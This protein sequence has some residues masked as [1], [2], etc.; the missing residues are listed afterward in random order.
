MHFVGA[1]D[2]LALC[3]EEKGGTKSVMQGGL[4]RVTDG[5]D[6]FQLLRIP[7]TDLAGQ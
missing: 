4:L 5:L 6:V 7:K 3:L 2:Q 1:Q